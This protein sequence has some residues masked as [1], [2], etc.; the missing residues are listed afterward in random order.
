MNDIKRCLIDE[1]VAYDRQIGSIIADR[2]QFTAEQFYNK[3]NR[4]A[5]AKE[6]LRWVHNYIETLERKDEVEPDQDVTAE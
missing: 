5:T 4:I 3:V 2:A 6:T 1:C